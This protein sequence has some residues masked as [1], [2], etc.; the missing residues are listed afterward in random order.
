M[1]YMWSWKSHRL[2][3]HTWLGLNLQIGRPLSRIV[4]PLV[5]VT[6]LL[7]LKINIK[8]RISIFHRALKTISLKKNYQINQ[9]LSELIKL[10]SA[11]KILK[12]FLKFVRIF[13]N[14]LK[15]FAKIMVFE[16]DSTDKVWKT[17]V[18]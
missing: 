4:V 15:N 17:G 7:Q 10:S 12:Y 13:K 16:T 14:F 1:T 3:S 9:S 11:G 8:S 6:Q 2:T 5:L 18:F